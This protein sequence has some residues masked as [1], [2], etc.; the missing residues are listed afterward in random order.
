MLHFFSKYMN[1][2]IKRKDD[3]VCKR[4]TQLVVF[5]ELICD[6][7]MDKVIKTAFGNSKVEISDFHIELYF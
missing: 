5:H 3:G 2:S 6:L 4:Q 1:C 7:T